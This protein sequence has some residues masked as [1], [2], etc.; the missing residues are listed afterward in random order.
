MTTP[1]HGIVRAVLAAA[2]A[3]GLVYAAGA[4]SSTVDLAPS[5]GTTT[6]A[7][8]AST[9]AAREVTLSC[10]GPELRGVAGVADLS[11]TGTVSAAAAP[12]QA[13]GVLAPAAG[14]GGLQLGP[15]S[16]QPG[17]AP[18]HPA[19]GATIAL[20]LPDA[21]AA[22]EV[23]GTGSLAAGLVGLQQW[24]S[25]TG[26][27]RGLATVPCTPAGSD[28]WLLGGGGS[29]GRQERLL[30]VNPGANEVVAGLSLHGGAGRI[31]SPTGTGVTVPAH[32]R[33]VVLLDALDATEATPAVHV[34][35]SGGTVAAFLSDVWLDGSVPAGAD[36]SPPTAAPARSQVIP[37]AAFSGAG[38]VRVA[39]PGAQEAV[40]S[41]RLIGPDGGTPL[42]GTG[43]TRVAAGAVGQLSMAGAPAGTY[44]VEVNADVPV[45]A[46]AFVQRRAGTDPGDIA[47]TPSTE[48]VTGTAG[49]AFPPP[50]PGGAA[51]AAAPARVLSLVATDGPA[52]A[53]V[54]TVVA[55][56]ATTRQVVLAADTSRTVELGPASSVWVS[57]VGGPGALRAGVSS[58]VGKGAA[59]LVSALPLSDAVVTSLVST[60]YPAP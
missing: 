28:A 53:Q 24:A 52:T 41:A 60:A 21:S 8:G 11:V 34:Q 44:A 39:V 23:R 49:T 1:V 51:G 45:V 37:V 15:S 6:A 7:P 14:A 20:P 42:P 3:A 26:R 5:S 58:T 19:R 30:L 9:E 29:P 43:V 13:L 48:P 57:R 47:W 31:D 16:A 2:G 46:A 40:V 25:D 22:V 10:P 55:G 50:A 33:A 18:Q 59:Q 17:P 32:G 54:V 4:V 12:P 38:V 27:L 35:V 36:T 56:R